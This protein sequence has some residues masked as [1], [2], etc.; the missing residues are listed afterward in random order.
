MSHDEKR[1]DPGRAQILLDPAR[2]ARWDPENFLGRFAIQP[3]QAVVDVGS[4]PG[5]WTLPLAK[6]V[7]PAGVVWALDGSQD[8]LDMLAEREPPP[9]VHPILAELPEIRLPSAAVDLAWAAFVYHEVP[10][11]EV[12]ASELR[13]VLKP[14]GTAAILEWRP[15]GIG[16]AGAPRSH[17]VQPAQVIAWLNA[18]GFAEPVQSWRDDDAYLVE[19]HQK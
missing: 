14:G 8:L 19:A 17:R 2:L 15:D 18:A 12:L 11:P 10:Q 9:Q 5:F 4:G 6:M 16:E 1:F 13:R 3:G 7:G